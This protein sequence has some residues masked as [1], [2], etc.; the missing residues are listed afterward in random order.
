M[1]RNKNKI[2]IILVSSVNINITLKSVCSMLQKR[3]QCNGK[4]CIQNCRLSMIL[5]LS[6]K[7]ILYTN[8]IRFFYCYYDQHF[9][10]FISHNFPFRHFQLKFLFHTKGLQQYINRY[11]SVV[12][13]YSLFF[14]VFSFFSS[15]FFLISHLFAVSKLSISA[16]FQ[17]MPYTCTHMG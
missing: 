4:S 12:F 15:F 6:C 16:W 14:V 7:L 17:P 10:I 8:E 3:W 11:N 9:R 13:L 5:G 1:L 2:V